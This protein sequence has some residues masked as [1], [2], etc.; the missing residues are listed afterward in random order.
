[1]SR[2]GSNPEPAVNKPPAP[3]NPP[4][5]RVSPK[6]AWLQQL[7]RIEAKLDALLKALA[8]DEEQP[9]MG[10]ETGTKPDVLESL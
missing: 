3:P 10:L 1:M 9:N 4:P 8:E 6:A 2:V 5:E 7:D